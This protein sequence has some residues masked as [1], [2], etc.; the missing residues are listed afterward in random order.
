MVDNDHECG[1]SG[2]YVFDEVLLLVALVVVA[3]MFASVGHGGASGYLAVLSLTAYATNDPAWLKQH[4]WCLNL[5]VAA[6]AFAAFRSAGHFRMRLTAPFLIA[7]MPMA[8]VGASLPIDGLLY[9]VMLSAL[10]LLAAWRLLIDLPSQEGDQEDLRS[11]HVPSALILGGAIG[12]VSGMIGVGGGIFLTPF[13]ILFRWAPPKEAAA[14]SA[15]FIWLNS[16]AGLAGAALSPQV[17]LAIE[18]MTVL[19]FGA[20]VCIGG[21][22]GSRWGAQLAEPRQIRRMLAFVLTLASGRRLIPMLFGFF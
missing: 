9:D 22:V 2:V 4:A 3:A 20:A 11:L 15:A 8:F 10:L 17:G 7:S 19:V 1:R 18:P 16:A 21:L 13:L 14:T 5:L 12:F 6:I